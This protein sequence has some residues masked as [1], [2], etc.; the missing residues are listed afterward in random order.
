MYL[1]EA[2]VLEDSRH[3]YVR[4]SKYKLPPMGLWVTGD[5]S[6]LANFPRLIKF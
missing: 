5:S 3:P 6:Q 2:Q 1:V 4:S